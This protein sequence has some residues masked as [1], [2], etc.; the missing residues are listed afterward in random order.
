MGRVFD[1]LLLTSIGNPL[2]EGTFLF[3]KGATTDFLY[4]NLSGGEKA[5][6]DLIL[7]VVIGRTVYKNSVFCIDEPDLHL[8]TRVQAKLLRELLAQVPENGQLWIATHAIG[9]MAAA[10][11][12]YRAAP[13]SVVFLDFSD[14]DFDLAQTLQPSKPTRGFWLR[15][16]DVALDDLS[17]LMSPRLLVL[18]EGNIGSAGFDSRCYRTIFTS[19]RPDTE[20]VSVGGDKDVEADRLQ[21]VALFTAVIPGAQVLRLI[22]R[23]DRSDEEVRQLVEGGVHVLPRRAIENYLLDPEVVRAFCKSIGRDDAVDDVIGILDDALANSAKRGNPP[24]DVKSAAGEFYSRIRTLLKIT[25]K[26]NDYREFA[27][28]QLAPLM[29]PEM[30]VYRELEQAIFTD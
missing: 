14:R 29:T 6:F 11:E 25:Q 27:A 10:V 15:T 26:G 24:D 23:D 2:E 21:L 5:A 19:E 3:A 30:S 16:L 8:N 28:T 17:T 1:D 12:M 4:K 18:C 20:F 22:D 9:F 7:D 13:D